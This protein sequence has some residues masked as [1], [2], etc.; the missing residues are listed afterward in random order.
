M[1]SLL[2]RPLRV[3]GISEA[4]MLCLK[5]SKPPPG[6]LSALATPPTCSAATSAFG[7]GVGH[8]VHAAQQID[9]TERYSTLLTCGGVTL[10][11]RRAEARRGPTIHHDYWWTVARQVGAANSGVIGAATTALPS[12]LNLSHNAAFTCSA[13]GQRVLAYGGR[14]KHLNFRDLRLNERGIHLA[15]GTITASATAGG[16]PPTIAWSPPRLVL[17]GTSGSGCSEYLHECCGVCS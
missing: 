9:C 16:R 7:A 10:L 2:K 3:G 6:D 1:K 8:A 17:E 15:V 4:D 13:D 12:M 14:R 11:L 5:N